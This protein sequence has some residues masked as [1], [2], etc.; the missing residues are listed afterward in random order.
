MQCV[1][2]IHS[3]YLTS[4][5]YHKRMSP[6]F[7]SMDW[8]RR[9]LSLV[10][11][12]S[13]HS[14]FTMGERATVIVADYCIIAWWDIRRSCDVCCFVLVLGFAFVEGKDLALTFCCHI[15]CLLGRSNFFLFPLAR[16]IIILARAWCFWGVVTVAVAVLCLISCVCAASDVVSSGR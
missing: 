12:L 1:P 3:Q 2:I 16:E 14:N 13:S 15:W 7:C 5:S 11:S 8:H 10:G 6:F 9:V 4:S